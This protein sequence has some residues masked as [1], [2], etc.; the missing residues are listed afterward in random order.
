MSGKN[1]AEDAPISKT[2]ECPVCMAAVGQPCTNATN[3][4]RR[5]VKWFHLKRTTAA[6]EMLEDRF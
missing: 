3:T 2:V 6:M 4:S 1:R 5:E